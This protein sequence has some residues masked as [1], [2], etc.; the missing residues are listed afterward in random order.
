M[1]KQPSLNLGAWRTL[2][3]APGGPVL[4]MP[5]HHLTTHAVVLGMTGSGKPVS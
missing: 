4:L 2:D 1:G 5:P 3:G